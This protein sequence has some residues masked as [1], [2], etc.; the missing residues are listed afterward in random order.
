[1]LKPHEHISSYRNPMTAP[2]TTERRIATSMRRIAVVG[3]SSK[4]TAP[5][6]YIPAYLQSQGIEVVPVNP[7]A[8]ELLGGPAFASLAEV[9]GP[10]DVV[11]V[12]RPAS[13]AS[14]ITR[15]AA[16]LGAAAVWLQEGLISTAAQA[17]AN[18]AGIDFVMDRC[19]GVTHGEL[20]LGP[21]PNADDTTPVSGS[22]AKSLSEDLVCKTSTSQ[23]GL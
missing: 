18:D 8:T 9:R 23:K 6:N 3:A 17:I 10:I 14:E 2:T 12:F 11:V 15:A 5:G 1:M 7:Q 22:T 4:P 21:G 20:G 16:E 19:I 13:E